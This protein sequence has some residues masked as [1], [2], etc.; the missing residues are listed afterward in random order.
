M[1][2]F[3]LLD[4]IRFLSDQLVSAHDVYWEIVRL[5]KDMVLARLGLNLSS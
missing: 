3:L 5:R 4:R 1:A 2:A